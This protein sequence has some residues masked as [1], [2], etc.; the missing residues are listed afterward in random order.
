MVNLNPHVLAA[1]RNGGVAYKITGL[2]RRPPRSSPF[3]ADLPGLGVVP[4]AATLFVID[5]NKRVLAELRATLRNNN[6]IVVCR[7]RNVVIAHNV[8]GWYK[9]RLGPASCRVNYPSTGSCGEAIASDAE[10]VKICGPIDE[11]RIYQTECRAWAK[12]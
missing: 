5:D 6:P 11:S 1:A 2:N 3:T 4:A 7:K 10:P 9:W 8:F 12:W